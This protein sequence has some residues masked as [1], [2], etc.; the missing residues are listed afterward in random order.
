[1]SWVNMFTSW[2]TYLFICQSELRYRTLLTTRCLCFCFWIR[3]HRSVGSTARCYTRRNKLPVHVRFIFGD[4]LLLV[5]EP[6]QSLYSTKLRSAANR[7]LNEQWVFYAIYPVLIFV[8]AIHFI[9][10]RTFEWEI[11]VRF[12]FSGA[13]LSSNNFVVWISI[14]LWSISGFTVRG[15][16]NT[17]SYVH[18]WSETIPT[19]LCSPSQGQ[20]RDRI[21]ISVSSNFEVTMIAGGDAGSFCNTELGI[22]LVQSIGGTTRWDWPVEGKRMRELLAER[23]A[24]RRSIPFPLSHLQTWSMPIVMDF[25]WY[26]SI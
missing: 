24:T 6:S 17:E 3:M 12:R 7:L 25:P 14:F 2:E 13:C 1:M 18:D 22:K 4:D 8:F 23:L 21:I 20:K 9:N 11:H 5:V 26:I 10:E 16:W 15:R 19:K